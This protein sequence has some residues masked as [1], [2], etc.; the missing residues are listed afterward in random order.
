MMMD[1]NEI[2]KEVALYQTTR[3]IRGYIVDEAPNGD[4]TVQTDDGRTIVLRGILQ[5]A[6]GA[7]VGDR[8][9][10]QCTQTK[11]GL[12]WLGYRNR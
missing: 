6:N 7:E 1:V 5:R 3:E 12:M 11:H 4:Q 8:V 10:L 9:L 2:K